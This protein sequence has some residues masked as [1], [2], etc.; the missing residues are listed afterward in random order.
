[1]SS[2]KIVMPFFTEAVD[3]EFIRYDDHAKSIADRNTLNGMERVNHKYE[4]EK[5]GS[6]RDFYSKQWDESKLEVEK[7]K[8]KITELQMELYGEKP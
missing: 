2:E 3:G 8:Q 4:L 6:H 7:L 5:L 1:M